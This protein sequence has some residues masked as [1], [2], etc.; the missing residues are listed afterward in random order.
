M[1]KSIVLR[2]NRDGTVTFRSGRYVEH[3]DVRMLGMLETYEA[4][5]YAAVTAGVSLTDDLLAEL[6]REARNLKE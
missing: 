6:L 3:I 5:R 1:K 4:I 2:R